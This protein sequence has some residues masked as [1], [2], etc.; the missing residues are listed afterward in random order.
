MNKIISRLLKEIFER[1]QKRRR[2]SVRRYGSKF[3]ESKNKKIFYVFKGECEEK[4]KIVLNLIK[5]NA[6]KE[7]DDY[8]HAAC[9]IINVGSIK[10]LIIAYKLIKEYRKLGGQKSWGFKKKYFSNQN[11]GK[12]KGEIEKEIKKKIGINPRVLDKY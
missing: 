8:Y 1:D 11:W 7:P 3:S 2:D 10:N 6:L 9:I 12:S 5:N 4:T